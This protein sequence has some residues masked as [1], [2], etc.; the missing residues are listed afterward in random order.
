MIRLHV[1]AEGQTEETFVNK[2][3]RP[4]L[5]DRGIYV[6]V[7]CI[8]TRKMRSRRAAGG[9]VPYE[10]FKSDLD[11]WIANDDNED[12]WFTT[13]IDLYALPHSFPGREPDSSLSDPLQRVATIEEAMKS[14]EIYR[15]FVPYI[16]LHEF[17]TLLFVDPKQLD[18]E[19]PDHETQITD[20]VK[21][22]LEFE[23][24]EHI[25][26][27]PTTAPS[28]QISNRIP[29]YAARK[30]SAGPSVAEQIGLDNLRT[31]CRHFGEWI[32]R[33]ETLASC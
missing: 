13:M 24:P 5:A 19:F 30:A 28:K 2:V 8:C 22:S 17:E 12:S 10:L 23:S 33:L 26:D 7:R 27:N 21:L 4:Y 6:D 15:R 9:I 31:S 14:D 11:R 16:Q 1:L 3:V 20:L 32:S 29:E 25:N 18:W